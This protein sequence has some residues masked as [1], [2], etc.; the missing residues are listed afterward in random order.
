[1]NSITD[2]S[3][4]IVSWNV[5][6][7]LKQCLASILAHVKDVS[8]EIFVVDN[9]SSDG[10]AE[11][12]K[13]E[14]PQAALI[15]NPEN[16]GFARANNK[17]LIKARGR[18]ILFL[19]PDT[20][21]IDNALKAIVDFMDAHPDAS[22]MA[23]RLV[24]EDRTLQPNCRHFPTLAAD[25]WESLYL[26]VLFPK[27]MIFNRYLMGGWAHESVREVD[28]PYG[29]CLLFRKEVIDKTGLMDE[30]FFMYYD[31]VDLCYRVKKDGGK[32]LFTPDITIIHH[33]NKSSIQ[34]ADRCDRNK[35]HSKL[36]FFKKHYGI[37]SIWM[38]GL[39]LVYRSILVWPGFGLSH[40]IFRRPRDP[41]YFRTPVR[42]MWKEIIVFLK[43]G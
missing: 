4:I 41:E 5:K 29:A 11:M 28:Q 18:Y 31:E 32:I 9:H 21:L 37:I 26:N 43:R 27:S 1:M 38:L 23:P 10:S 15:G 20:E 24:Y 2:L 39:N 12:V 34:D 30:R 33:A 25:L 3:I 17:A 7:Y 36:L 40:L 14:F 16:Y 6:G 13:K 22:G 19:N 35:F 42:M 8:Y